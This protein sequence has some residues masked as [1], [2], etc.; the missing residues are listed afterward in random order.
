MGYKP[1]LLTNVGSNQEQDGVK[2]YYEKR[3]GNRMGSNLI[4]IVKQ[5]GVKP[6][7]LTN[8]STPFMNRKRTIRDGVKPNLLT[9]G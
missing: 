9:N 7:L 8:V 5:D 4:R 3:T 1:N 6:N 2:P